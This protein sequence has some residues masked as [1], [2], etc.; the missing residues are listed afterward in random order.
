MLTGD[1]D[2]LRD[3]VNG[4]LFRAETT[5]VGPSTYKTTGGKLAAPRLYVTKIDLIGHS[6]W[7]AG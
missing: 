5:V 6:T 7:P 3:V 4:D 1:A 2:L